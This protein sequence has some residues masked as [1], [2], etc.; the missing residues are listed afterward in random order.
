M[1]TLR[2]VTIGIGLLLVSATLAS[3]QATRT[4]VS[5]GR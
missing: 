5:G 2:I 1:R 3:A 4:W